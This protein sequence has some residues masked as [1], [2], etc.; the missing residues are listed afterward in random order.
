LHVRQQVVVSNCASYCWSLLVPH[1]GRLSTLSVHCARLAGEQTA[2]YG[3][4]H[5]GQPLD[6]RC[7]CMP[8]TQS[9]SVVG[10][11][12]Q[13]GGWTAMQVGQE[14]TLETSGV[15]FGAHSGRSCM[16]HLGSG[17][18]CCCLHDGQQVV[19]ST[20]GSCPAAQTGKPGA[21]IF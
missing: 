7:G 13:A 5:D 10:S 21:S 19:V 9:G 17:G 14:V 6:V 20:V 4:T 16:G 15:V 3:T 11:V 12:V 8:A 1:G 2:S 18:S